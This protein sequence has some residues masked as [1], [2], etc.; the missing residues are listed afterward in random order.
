[1]NSGNAKFVT[2]PKSRLPRIEK[3][4]GKISGPLLDRID[5]RVE[6]TSSTEMSEL[7][8][9]VRK[10]QLDR[11]DGT[12]IMHNAP[13]LSPQIREGCLLD[14][15]CMNLL[16]ISVNKMDLSTRAHDKVLRL[17]FVNNRAIMSRAFS[18]R[19]SVLRRV[20]HFFVT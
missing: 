4:M 12:S 9:A 20:L 16:K 5:F 13:M 17:A 18:L 14:V 1:M 3:Y 6:G 10:A 11:F 2:H 15:E 8:V 7:V 19:S